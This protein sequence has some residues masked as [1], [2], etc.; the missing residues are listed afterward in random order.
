M[1][2]LIISSLLCGSLLP[3]QSGKQVVPGTSVH[4]YSGI[5]ALSAK[6]DKLHTFDL[7]GHAR[8]VKLSDATTIAQPAPYAEAHWDNI[9]DDL[10]W[11]I[12]SDQPNIRTWRPSTKTYTTVIDYAGRFESITTGATTDITFDNWEAFWA[13]HEHQLC[14]V[15]LTA[16]KTYCVDVNAPDPNNHLPLTTPDVD[17]VA[18]TP[19]DSKSGL[20]YVLMLAAPAMGVFSVDETAGKLRWVV[21]PEAVVPLMGSGRQPQN[22]DG[23][24]DPG[25]PCETTPHGDVYVAPDGQV[26]FQFQAGMETYTAVY[27]VCEAGQAFMRLNAGLKMT[28]PENAFGV[29]GGGLKYKGPDFHCGGEAWSSQHTGCARWGNHCI[30]SFDT[31]PLQPG[32]I[33]PRAE[34]LW[35]IG[36]DGTGAITYRKLG[37]SGTSNSSND[38]WAS[39]ELRCR[40]TVPRS[41]TTQTRAQMEKITAYMLQQL[42]YNP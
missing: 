2:K 25:E 16:K 35:L 7:E 36:I 33:A 23:N 10:M 28:T 4:Q 29:T 1:G 32:Q 8:I 18:V 39:I 41:F 3:A 37:T 15:D 12:G 24:C 30:I 20:H 34:E 19:R 31:G 40:W 21:R 38:Y 42:G 26:Y 27:N 17:Y 13:P 9:D 14:A 6:K 5:S 22:N 11:V